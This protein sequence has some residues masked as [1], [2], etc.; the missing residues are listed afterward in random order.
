M[1]KKLIS[2]IIMAGAILL[3]TG[4]TTSH[5]YS[6]VSED[7]EL[8]TVNYNS[9]SVPVPFAITG[10]IKMSINTKWPGKIITYES[11][12]SKIVNGNTY[13]FKISLTSDTI[14][15][16]KNG[17]YLTTHYLSTYVSHVKNPNDITSYRSK[18]P[19]SDFADSAT[20]K[21]VGYGVFMS[22]QVF[23][24]SRSMDTTEGVIQ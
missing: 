9:G 22:T 14:K 20:H 12:Y 21:A 23:P 19:N 16:Y 24:S 15:Y 1:K 11:L 17:S 8:W 5:A 7:K 10:T 18:S 6:N 3:G 4:A 13:P 2:S